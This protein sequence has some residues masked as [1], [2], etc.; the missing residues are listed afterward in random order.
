MELFPIKSVS[1]KLK[2]PCSK[3]EAQRAILIAAL[4]G[5]PI[6]IL[7]DEPSTDVLSVIELLRAAGFGIVMDA[8]GISFLSFPEKKSQLTLNVNESGFAFRSL[9]TISLH[10]A[11]TVILEA[12]RSLLRRDFTELVEHLTLI[13]IDVHSLENKQFCIS[14]QLSAGEYTLQAEDSSQSISGIFIALANLPE[15]S[16]ITIKSAVS[17]PYLQLTVDILRKFGYSV[18]QSGATYMFKGKK[19]LEN[20]SYRI[21]GDWSSAAVWF[22]AAALK[23]EICLSGLNLDS[24]QP[25]KIILDV[26]QQ[27]GAKVMVHGCKIGVC[28]PSKELQPFSLDLMNCPDLF[29][30]LAIFACGIS[31]TSHFYSTKRL[32]NKESDRI[33][34][35]LDMLDVFGVS[36]QSTVDSISIFGVGKING[37]SV[38]V[39]GDHRLIMAATLATCVCDSLIYL[40]DESDVKKSYISFFEHWNNNTTSLDYFY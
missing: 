4:Q 28:K 13:G 36:Y 5:Q 21:G 14:G 26:I 37:G 23:G 11:E 9:A 1:G 40:T 10:W 24:Y 30:V 15:I 3:S 7:M 16:K 22:A 31:G 8:Q 19:S 20:F 2:V 32:K 34:S 12:Q 27:A 29:P 33:T 25:D 17:F 18:T 6:R 39:H 38:K 35:I